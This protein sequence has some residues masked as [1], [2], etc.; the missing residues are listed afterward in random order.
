MQPVVCGFFLTLKCSYLIPAVA[1]LPCYYPITE[2]MRKTRKKEEWDIRRKCDVRRLR[3]AG[4]RK[5]C[6]RELHDCVS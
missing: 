6:C 5:G 3:R 1:V 2:T 4:L